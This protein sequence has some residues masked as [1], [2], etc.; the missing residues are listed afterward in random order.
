[1]SIKNETQLKTIQKE[2]YI[3]DGQE[4]YSRD[5]AIGVLA[6]QANKDVIDAYISTIEQPRTRSLVEKHLKEFVKKQAVALN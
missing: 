2:V 5:E 1:M 6:T 3:V 4:Y